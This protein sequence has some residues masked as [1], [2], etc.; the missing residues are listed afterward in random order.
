MLCG[1]CFAPFAASANDK[2]EKV[3]DIQRYQKVCNGKSQSEQV[4]FAYRGI[5]WNGTCEPQFFPSANTSSISGSEPELSRRCI[6]DRNAT[7]IN[8]NGTEIKGQCALGF[9]AP[10]PAPL[11]MQHSQPQM[12]PRH[13]M[14]QPQPDMH[15]K[16]QMKPQ[17]SP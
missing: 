10:H 17:H 13:H 2:V 4:S 5:I 6:R 16:P 11:Q 1:L 14:P 15:I 8:I 12:Q 3:Y 7:T 9:M